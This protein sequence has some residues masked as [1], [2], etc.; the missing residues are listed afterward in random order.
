M[1]VHS[2]ASLEIGKLITKVTS[3]LKILLQRFSLSFLSA[4]DK[5]QWLGSKFFSLSKF[6]G[7]KQ[8]R[9]LENSRPAFGRRAISKRRG[10]KKKRKKNWIPFPRIDI[11]NISRFKFKESD[12]R[13]AETRRYKIQAYHSE[14]LF[15][16][17]AVTQTSAARRFRIIPPVFAPSRHPSRPFAI[18]FVSSLFFF[19]T[20]SPS[21]TANAF[22]SKIS[23]CFSFNGG[24]ADIH[25]VSRG[26][27]SAQ[28]NG[29]LPRYRSVSS[30]STRLIGPAHL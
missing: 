1:C 15:A 22:R 30:V 23:R 17:H 19:C 11:Y 27:C 7:S 9:K 3:V 2:K 18:Y 26:S 28:I 20:L 12:D 5:F 25:S 14:I 16:K 29:F 10:A 21:A 13:A 24:N 8:N 4:I 6:D